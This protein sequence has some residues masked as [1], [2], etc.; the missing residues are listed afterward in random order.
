LVTINA[1]EFLGN[2][3]V[4]QT[5]LILIGPVSLL[6]LSW[7]LDIGLGWTAAGVHMRNEGGDDSAL[8]WVVRV[9][10]KAIQT[11]PAIY[12]AERFR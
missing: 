5:D 12:H 6:L 9:S 3:E 8:G 1:I 7:K 11:P 4:D 10:H 2:Q